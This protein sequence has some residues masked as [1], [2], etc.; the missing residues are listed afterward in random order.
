MAGRPNTREY[1]D[2]SLAVQTLGLV[3][4]GWSVLVPS[5]SMGVRTAVEPLLGA[6]LHRADRCR[7]ACTYSNRRVCLCWYVHSFGV[8]GRPVV[9]TEG[10][11]GHGMDTGGPA[12]G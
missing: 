6:F 4:S 5:E 3:R 7:A 9:R 2:G 11:P 12:A 10:E 8:V 1:V